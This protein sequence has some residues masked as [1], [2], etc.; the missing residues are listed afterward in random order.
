M[1]ATT[2]EGT[3]PGSVYNVKPPIINGV[4]KNSNLKLERMSGEV[5][6]VSL[7]TFAADEV[8]NSSETYTDF[9]TVTYNPVLESSLILVEYHA[10]YAVNGG[11]NDSF[12]SKITVNGDEI[13]W[14]NQLWVESEGG[15]T[16]SGVLFPISMV[17]DNSE[18][19]ASLEIKV[20]ASRDGSDDTLTVNSNN[21]Y[22]KITE[23]G[24]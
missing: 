24:K 19:Y 15:G 20:S 11:G 7:H 12:R 5:V 3:G 22:L 17:Y 18:E 6:K 1:P 4:V 13:T 10:T 23:V 8:T 14:R 21:S 16:R 9:A 2:T